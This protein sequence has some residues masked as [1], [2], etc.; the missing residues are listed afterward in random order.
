[1][2]LFNTDP[3]LVTGPCSWYLKNVV[4][5]VWLPTNSQGG[6]ET[7]ADEGLDTGHPGHTSLVGGKKCSFSTAGGLSDIPGTTP[8]G[9]NSALI[10]GP[11]PPT[12]RP[13][14]LPH[15]GSMACA[16]V[17]ESHLGH[18]AD[19]WTVGW[20]DHVFAMVHIWVFWPY[21]T[22]LHTY[23]IFTQN[24]KGRICSCESYKPT[25]WQKAPHLIWL[26]SS[27]PSQD[28]TCLGFASVWL[29]AESFWEVFG[30]G[31]EQC[32]EEK[33]SRR[34]YR[35]PWNSTFRRKVPLVNSH[36]G[37]SNGCSRTNLNWGMGWMDWIS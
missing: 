27:T 3:I 10:S 36:V 16:R 23:I 26:S 8:V 6:V 21:V 33:R 19:I 5:Q 1:M 25:I 30:K 31:F 11:R 14:L 12:A 13:F 2:R 37:V 9:V 32:S 22:W 29:E 35:N 24:T 15:L 18:S 17:H 7:R 34:R 20:S 4:G 28:T